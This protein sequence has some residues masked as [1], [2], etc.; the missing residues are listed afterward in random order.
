MGLILGVWRYEIWKYEQLGHIEIG[1]DAKFEFF[2]VDNGENDYV[3]IRFI[4][5]GWGIASYPFS[6]MDLGRKYLVEVLDENCERLLWEGR[7]P[8]KIFS[9]GENLKLLFGADI[10]VAGKVYWVV[11]RNETFYLDRKLTA[12][13]SDNFSS[14]G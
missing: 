1:K 9:A 3:E 5:G 7:P 14:M 11:F 12:I 6:Y 8:P 13:G 2:L 10:C 4:E